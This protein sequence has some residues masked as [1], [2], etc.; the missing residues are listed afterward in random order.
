[1][2]AAVSAGFARRAAALAYDALL[3]AAVLMV[4]TA[5]ALL[6]T[7]GRAILPENVGAWAYLYRAAL[8]GLVAGYFVINWV[9]SGQTLGMRAWHLHAVD[10]R[11]AL[12]VWQVALL[13]FV[14]AVACW[15]PAGLGVFWMYLDPRHLALHDRLSKT[16]LLYLAGP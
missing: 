16:R 11:G 6:M 10:E 7:H 3:L 8:G 5:A 12:L 4:F 13:R 2:S 1:M 14:C 9:R 15:V